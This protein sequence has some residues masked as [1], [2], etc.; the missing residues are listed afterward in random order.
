MEVRQGAL[1]PRVPP[2]AVLG[3]HAHDQRPDLAHDRQPSRI[4]TGTA[5]VLGGDQ[6]SVP[7]QQRVRRHDR[8]ELAQ[9]PST[10]CPGLRG[11]PTTLIVREAQASGSKLRA[12]DAVLF[13]Q[14]VDDVAL[15]LVDPTGE[16]DQDELQRMRQPRLGG[17][18][19]SG[20]VSS[21][22]RSAGSEPN[23]ST[24]GRSFRSIGFLDN[25]ATS[26]G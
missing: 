13:L 1:D 4:T 3:G 24:E 25:S 6:G 12:Q 7:C 18:A 21:A 23:P 5:V 2:A 9:Q 14:I 26:E 22:T 16:R 11:E 17:Q 20:W 19:T 8:G 10:E 15:L